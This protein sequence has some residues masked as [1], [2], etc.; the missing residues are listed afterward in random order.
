MGEEGGDQGDGQVIAITSS[1]VG[2][3]VYV[4]NMVILS[5][6][7]LGGKVNVDEDICKGVVVNVCD[8]VMGLGEHQHKSELS[9]GRNES[10]GP[11][12][13]RDRSC[14]WECVMGE[15]VELGCAGDREGGR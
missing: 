15:A 14:I 11:A 9:M 8:M 10:A 1:P 5:S 3:V 12:L 6:H 2:G 7:F 13:S 4:V